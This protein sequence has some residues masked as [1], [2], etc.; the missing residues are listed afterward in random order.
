MRTQLGSLQTGQESHTEMPPVRVSR[1]SSTVVCRL[2][3]RKMNCGCLVVPRLS[4][5]D[6]GGEYQYDGAVPKIY[7]WPA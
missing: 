3:R 5:S 7:S 6:A 1:A 4:F 2:I